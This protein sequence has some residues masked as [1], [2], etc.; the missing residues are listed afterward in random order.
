[1]ASENQEQYRQVSG[2]L[3]QKSHELAQI[4]EQLD[5]VKHEMEERGSSMTDG[6]ERA[7]PLVKHIMFYKDRVL[8]KKKK[9]RIQPKSR[10]FLK[11]YGSESWTLKNNLKATFI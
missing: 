3:T 4:T 5:R 2:N 11:L 9:I 6:S 7:S 10:S 1:M 8:R